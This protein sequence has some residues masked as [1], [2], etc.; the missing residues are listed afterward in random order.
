M[1]GRIGRNGETKTLAA[2]EVAPGV[3]SFPGLWE[4]ALRGMK[5]REENALLDKKLARSG[6][7]MDK[8]LDA[9]MIDPP[10][11]PAELL[12]GDRVFAVL[13]IRRMTHGDMYEFQTV[14]PNCRKPFLWE[15][16]IGEFPVHYLAESMQE[17]P[18]YRHSTLL[19][20]AG[21]SVEWRFLRGSDEKRLSDASAR[22]PESLASLMMLLR[23]TAIEGEGQIK[24]EF[25]DDLEGGDSATLR[26]AF[27]LNDCG[28]DTDIVVECPHCDFVHTMDLPLDI[29]FFVP[30]KA[31]RGGTKRR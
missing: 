24:Q 20:Q 7:V 14:C 8:L 9:C 11:R 25:F 18:T 5:T 13:Q 15:E 23:A 3:F 19:P 16:N 4:G 6:L 17:D 27:D 29:G 21:R 10:R 12:V 22:N 2:A 28:V 31:N 1:S 30:S 26:E